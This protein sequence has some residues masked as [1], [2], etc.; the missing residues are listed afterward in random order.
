LYISKGISYLQDKPTLFQCM[1]YFISITDNSEIDS[2][3]NSRPKTPVTRSSSSRNSPLSS[4]LVHRRFQSAS[5]NPSESKVEICSDDIEDQMEFFAAANCY[6]SDML[7]RE[8]IL[9]D[10]RTGNVYKC[11]YEG[12][13]NNE[14]S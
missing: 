8:K 10:G 1:A 7:I 6:Y 5:S 2:P 13:E 12:N 4:P 14:I 3:P 9:G 11:R